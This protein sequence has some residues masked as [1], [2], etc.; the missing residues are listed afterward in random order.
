MPESRGQE[1]NLEP[2]V[3]FEPTYSA[4]EALLSPSYVGTGGDQRT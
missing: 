3:G 2:T 4:Y 1:K